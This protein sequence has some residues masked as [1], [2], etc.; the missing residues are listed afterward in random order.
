MVLKKQ[1]FEIRICI[2]YKDDKDIFCYVKS[3]MRIFFSLFYQEKSCFFYLSNS[4]IFTLVT[5]WF[6]PDHISL[7]SLIA[8]NQR[9][10]LGL[11]LIHYSD[12]KICPFLYE[13]SFIQQN[14]LS[15]N[16]SLLVAIGTFIHRRLFAI[17]LLFN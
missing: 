10:I 2:Y 16:I 11:S 9:Q 6:I 12:L 3:C 17:T 13:H 4:F 1:L 8:R 5:L 15:L 14:V 7:F